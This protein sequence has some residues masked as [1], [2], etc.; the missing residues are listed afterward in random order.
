MSLFTVY[1]KSE[2]NF[3]A[4]PTVINDENS[5]AGEYE[6]SDGSIEFKAYSKDSEYSKND[7]VYVLIPEGNYNN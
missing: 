6:V 2:E 5:K 7:V 1:G 3:L 4:I